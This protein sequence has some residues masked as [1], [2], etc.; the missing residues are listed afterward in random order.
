MRKAMVLFISVMVFLFFHGQIQ[1]CAQSSQKQPAVKQKG[2]KSKI[3]VE[4]VA[5]PEQLK[6]YEVYPWETMKVDDFQKA[7]TKMISQG[8]L[9]EWVKS[10]TGTAASKNRM[11]RA[12]KEQFVLIVS[13]KPHM[14]DES[15][16]II[17][18]DPL[19]KQTFSILARDGKFYW[20]GD[21]PDKVRDLLNVLLVEEFKDVYRAG[22]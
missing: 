11:I 7:Y 10:L 5:F 14:C 12:F 13:C 6:H 1:L 4:Y 8:L 20:F 9:E 21:P 19:K 22:K 17:L 15:Q 18:Y 16:V 3:V 2:V